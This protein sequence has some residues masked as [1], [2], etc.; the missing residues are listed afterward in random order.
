MELDCSCWSLGGTLTGVKLIN[1]IFVE[2]DSGVFFSSLVVISK[3][4]NFKWEIINVYGPVQTERKL[5]FIQ[6]LTQKISNV[7]WSFLLGGDFNL[8]R[9]AWEKSSGNANQLWMDTFNN[10]ISDNGLVEL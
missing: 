5:E 7:Q 4:D 1:A 3:A 6:E 8:I 9:Y 10:I 2:K